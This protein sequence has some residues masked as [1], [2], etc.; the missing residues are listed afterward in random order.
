MR[1]MPGEQRVAVLD[2]HESDENGASSTRLREGATSPL[3]DLVYCLR[4]S[5][6]AHGLARSI[7]YH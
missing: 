6:C 4:E 7:E 5:R 1:E 3:I 2:R